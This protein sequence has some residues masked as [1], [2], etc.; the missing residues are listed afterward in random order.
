M[1]EDKIDEDEFM[2]AMKASFAG[3]EASLLDA[4]IKMA[5]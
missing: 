2:E 4:I 5:G 3:D 1:I